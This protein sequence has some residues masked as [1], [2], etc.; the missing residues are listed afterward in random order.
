MSLGLTSSNARPPGVNLIV[1]RDGTVECLYDESIDL[2]G[3]GRLTIAR[4]SHVEPTGSGQWTADLTPAS[5]P[6]LGPFRTRTEALHAERIWL[7]EH[8]L[9]LGR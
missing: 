5:G 7:E 1:H 9:H 3:I 4:A 2:A 8:R 6:V